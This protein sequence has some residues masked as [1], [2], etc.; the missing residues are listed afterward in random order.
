MPSLKDKNSRGRRRFEM[1]LSEESISSINEDTEHGS[2]D[3]RKKKIARTMLKKKARKGQPSK[4]NRLLIMKLD[5]SNKSL[6]VHQ[7]KLKLQMKKFSQAMPEI[8][9][10]KAPAAE[11]KHTMP[12]QY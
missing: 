7:Q 4:K 12:A 3:E 1:K 9:A 5:S 11:R 8:H 6:T 2:E 10:Q